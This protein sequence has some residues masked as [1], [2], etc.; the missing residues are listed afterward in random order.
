MRYP[1]Q[2]LSTRD[3]LQRVWSVDSTVSSDAVRTSIKRLRKKLDNGE[4]ENNS[5]I[6]TV[7]RVGYRLRAVESNC[8]SM[9]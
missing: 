7:A 4:D 3:I 8:M 1:D 6:E 9:H 5:I 2:I